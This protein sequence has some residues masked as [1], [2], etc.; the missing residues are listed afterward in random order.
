MNCICLV[1]E[2]FDCKQEVFRL[3]APSSCYIYSLKTN[4]APS[5]SVDVGMFYYCRES[6]QEISDDII[7]LCDKAPKTTAELQQKKK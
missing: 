3:P 4:R 1:F 6:Q 7:D 2:R 5:Q